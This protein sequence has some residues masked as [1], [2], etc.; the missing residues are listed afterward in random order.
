MLLINWKSAHYV[1]NILCL[2]TT[3]SVVFWCCYEY[4]Q[5]DDVC[6]ILFKR[7]H[8]DDESVYP[9]LTF[10]VP[11]QFDETALKK[12]NENFTADTYRKFLS[13]S[14]PWDERYLNV[15]FS[16]VSMPLQD[17][18]IET[19][20]QYSHFDKTCEKIET[21]VTSNMFGQQCNTLHFPKNNSMALAYIKL[22]T[23]I[24][25]SGIRPPML[26]FMIMFSFVNQNYASFEA[27]FNEWP[28]RSI[29]DKNPY[30]MQLF[31]KNMEVLRYRTKRDEECDDS[32]N[33]D[34][35]IKLDIIRK[36]GCR[37]IF[38]IFV[39]DIP[40]CK[41]QT[42]F[43]MLF[44]EH[45]DKT[46]RFRKGVKYLHPCRDI[47]KIQIE[48]RD[49]NNYDV[50]N[51]TIIVSS[52]SNTTDVNE[53]KNWFQIQFDI[54]V[55]TFK[56]IKQVRAY[57]FQSLVGNVGGYIGLFL[58]FSI[59]NLP[60]LSMDCWAYIK[61]SWFKESKYK[62][63]RSGHKVTEDGA[64]VV[65]EHGMMSINLTRTS[66]H[67]NQH[68]DEI[69]KLTLRNKQANRK[70]KERVDTVETRSD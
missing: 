5:N 62:P 42:E 1:F 15:N 19:C 56:E 18:M 49:V 43:Q 3:I 50:R 61:S 53:G 54:R 48:Y 12:Y 24:F 44:S 52:G 57:S 63:S 40:I 65:Q 64:L 13:G 37:P 70:L 34:Q 21:I 32:E 29:T 23:S 66:N 14:I 9:D 16:E 22:N 30:N 20:I 59:L 45:F 11:D 60:S 36:V 67:M 47:Q 58:G 35:R 46:T 31:L 39:E 38:W 33:Y 68:Y 26:D 10:C 7:F 28:M 41:T 69:I 4:S 6:E 17:Y 27:Y 2:C 55:N 8:G 25:E 51:N